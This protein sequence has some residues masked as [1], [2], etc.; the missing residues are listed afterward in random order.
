MQP[1]SNNRIINAAKN[2]LANFLDNWSTKYPLSNLQ[3][4]AILNGELSSLLW[5]CFCEEQPQSKHET[6]ADRIVILRSQLDLTQKQLAAK[7]GVKQST[8]SMWETGAAP[9]PRM[10]AKLAEALSTTPEY[11]KT[12]AR[13]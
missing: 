7:L 2:E 11:L 8:V 13:E 12:G 1:T 6:M 10:L 5:K 4:V 9:R 3:K